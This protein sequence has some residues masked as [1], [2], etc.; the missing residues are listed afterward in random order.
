MGASNA[1]EQM[2][3]TRAYCPDA[4]IYKQLVDTFK[5]LRINNL[6]VTCPDSEAEDFMQLWQSKLQPSLY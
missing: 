3:D 2:A 5:R 1:E 6:A 4:P